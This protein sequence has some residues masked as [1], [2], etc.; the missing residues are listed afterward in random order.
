[1][2]RND[3]PTEVGAVVLLRTACGSVRRRKVRSEPAHGK[4]R[5]CEST[6]WESTRISSSAN[7]SAKGE[8]LSVTRVV[9]GTSNSAALRIVALGSRER[10]MRQACRHLHGN[11]LG[12]DGERRVQAAEAVRAGIPEGHGPAVARCASIAA[13]SG[14]NRP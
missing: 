2:A 12:L 10:A 14:C 7:D 9:L 11:R 13:D 6:P 5:I 1:M 3:F 4:A 8:N